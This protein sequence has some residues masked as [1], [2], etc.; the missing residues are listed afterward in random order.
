MRKILAAIAG[1]GTGL[2]MLFAPSASGASGADD[3]A[4][5]APADRKLCGM[6]KRQHSY[7]AY[8]GDPHAYWSVPDGRTLV[9]ELTHQGMTKAE[10][11]AGLRGMAKEYQEYVTHVTVNMDAL[12][13]KCGNTDGQWVIG[14]RDEDGRPGGTKLTYKRIVCA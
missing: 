10:M 12:V 7:G 14:Y 9:H 2:L 3:C 13:K 11:H 5:V 1:I 4:R 8:Y 6:V